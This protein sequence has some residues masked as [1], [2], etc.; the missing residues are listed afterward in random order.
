MIGVR[1]GNICDTTRW[2]VVATNFCKNILLE[3]C[4][5]SSMD[6]HQGVS[7]TYTI[8]GCTLGHA[9]LNAI[10]RGVLCDIERTTKGRITLPL[11]AN[12]TH[13]S[14]ADRLAR[15]HAMLA[16]LH[17]EVP[18]VEGSAVQQTEQIL[19]AVEQFQKRITGQDAMFLANVGRCICEQA[20]EDR[21]VLCKG[22]AIV[23]PV[24]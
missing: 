24:Q 10:G 1:M 15:A 16:D 7:G 17:P 23:P 13:P 8:R 4:T 21:S 20:D 14:E 22:V 18:R 11:S 12:S 9:G 19:A 2:G 3:N 5:L 6:T